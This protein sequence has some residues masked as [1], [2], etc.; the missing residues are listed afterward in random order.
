MVKKLSTGW[1]DHPMCEITVHKV[2]GSLSTKWTDYLK[3]KINR[4][5]SGRIIKMVKKL[6]TRWADHLKCDKTIHKV[7]GSP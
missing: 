6:S 7:D 5:Q 2:D 3:G 4:P 1:T